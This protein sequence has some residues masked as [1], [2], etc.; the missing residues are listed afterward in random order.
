MIKSEK[1]Y[2]IDRPQE[3]V[4]SSELQQKIKAAEERLAVLAQIVGADFG[5]KIQ[6]GKI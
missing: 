3:E 6:F 5:M 4:A 1:S 2:G